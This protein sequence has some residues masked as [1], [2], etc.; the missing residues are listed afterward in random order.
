ME[1]FR[2]VSIIKRMTMP[3][4]QLQ[5]YHQELRKYE[6]DC[7]IKGIKLRQILHGAVLLCVKIECLLS[8]VRVKV[9]GDERIPTNKPIIYACTHIGRYDVESNFLS[10]NDHFYILYGDPRDVYRSLDGLLLN[11]NGVIYVDTD[12]KDDRF[13]GKE[14]CVKLL[15]KGGSLLIYPEG[16]WNITS[17]QAVMKLFTGSVEMAIRSEAQIVPI[18]MEN[19]GNSYYVNIGKNIDYAHASLTQKRELSDQLR[20]IM[21]TLKWEIWEK[22][23]MQKR[24]S[25]PIKYEDIFLDKI[26]S[27]TVSGYTVE[28]IERTRY[29]DKNIQS[30]EEVFAFREKLN[31]SK[32]NTFL[33]RNNK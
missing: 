23:G 32:S 3:Q 24:S 19:Q 5:Q 29:Q 30:Q 12:S 15:K 31:P 20:D 18:A 10:L 16:A 17:N 4:D 7:P 26:M 25:I 14:N 1:K 9:V 33:L 22:V 13:I 2:K 6:C 21:C 11:L 8:G 28:E 27:Q